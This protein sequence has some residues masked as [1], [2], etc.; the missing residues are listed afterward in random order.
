M[1]YASKGLLI[2][3]LGL[4]PG[5]S[6]AQADQEQ[7]QA[8]ALIDSHD[9]DGDRM[10]SAEEFERLYQ[11]KVEAFL[12]EQD[13]EDA[14]PIQQARPLLAWE[15]VFLELD[16]DDNRE[17]SSAELHA[18]PSLMIPPGQIGQ[19]GEEGDDRG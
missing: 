14:Q 15:T 9:I 4:A 1:R 18:D 8:D 5:W 3:L 6:L 2:A 19:R 11:E 13:R 10:L 17:L 12:A 16:I 7:A